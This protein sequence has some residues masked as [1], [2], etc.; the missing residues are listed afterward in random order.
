MKKITFPKLVFS[1]VLLFIF[2]FGMN[3]QTYCTPGNYNTGYSANHY[4]KNVTF[5][6][7]NNNSTATKLTSPYNKYSDYSSLSTIVS[8]NS[9]YPIS[10]TV[11]RDNSVWVRV[12]IDYNKNGIFTD[13]GESVIAMNTTNLPT[14]F[15]F[16]NSFI[17]PSTASFGYLRMRVITHYNSITD[18]CNMN[19]QSAEIEDY[20]LIIQ[21]TA[22]LAGNDNFAVLKNS[23]SGIA[24]QI[25]VSNNDLIGTANPAAGDHYSA[26]ST[27]LNGGAISEITD[28]VFQY[29]PAP[30]FIGADSF[31]YTFC[32]N[33]GSC[34]TAVVSINV[35]LAYCTPTT[36][37][38]GSHFINSVNLIGANATSINN[39]SG[40]NGGYGNFINLPAVELQKGLSYTL[41][42]K[43][44]PA[45]TSTTHRSGWAGYV[46]FNQNGIFEQ[47]SEVVYMTNGTG[48]EESTWPYLARTINI[49]A[50]ASLGRTVMRIGTRRYWASTDPCGN[51]SQPEE[52]EDYVVNV[53]GVNSPDIT[54][55]GNS[56]F[57]TNNSTSPNTSNNTS[58]GFYDV[59]LGN[60]TK[61]FTIRNDGSQPLNLSPISFFSSNAAFTLT[62]PLVT[63]VASNTF[64]T[65]TVSFDPSIVG[66]VEATI[67]IPSND[68]NKNPF[69]F[70][71]SGEGRKTFPDTDG[72]GIT[73]NLDLDD[74][75]DGLPDGYENATC[76]A[77]SRSTTA[78][79]TFL[80]EDFG[81]GTTRVPINGNVPGATTTYCYEDGTGSLCSNS[82]NVDDGDYTIYYT[83]TDKNSSTTGN[84]AIDVSSWADAF[85]YNGTDHTP[86]DTNGRMA[87]FNAAAE[88]GIFYST[89]V[90][91]ITPNV[92]IRF[93][94]YAINLDRTDAPCVNGTGLEQN[95]TTPCSGQ[96]RLRPR[97]QINIYDPNGTLVTSVTSADIQPTTNGN[98]AGDWIEVSAS[99]TST[100]SQFTV[101]LR[102]AQPG[103]LGNDLAIDDIYVKQ[104]LCDL[105]GDGVA[106]IYDL[107]NDDD[108]I[109]NVIEL[110]FPDLDK[111][112]M[113][114]G[115]GW[116]DGNNNGIHDT[117][118]AYGLNPI[119]PD[120]DGDGTPDYIDLDS[121][122][123]S[124]F[125]N[126][127]YDGKGDI[128]VDGNGTGDAKDIKSKLPNTDTD[129]DGI[130]HA[131]DTK[132]TDVDDR[133]FG[134]A[135]YA[136]P[137]DSD[138]DGIPDYRDVFHNVT[139][140]FDIATTIYASYDTNN[141]GR[142]DGT[143]DADKDGVLDI[144]D[145]DDIKNGSPRLL[146]N[147]YTLFFDGRNDY[148]EDS[149]DFVLGRTTASIMAWIKLENATGNEIVVG[150]DK[151]YL[152][153]VNSK[154]A[155]TINNAASFT[156]PSINNTIPLG[157]WCH[158][159][160]TYDGGLSS[161]KLKVYV[162]GELLSGTNVGSGINTSSNKL[163]RIGSAPFISNSNYFKGQIEEV[164]IFGT[165]LT[166]D[167]LQKMVYQ[168]LKTSDFKRGAVV[169]LD[170]PSLSASALLR[171]YQMDIFNND[172]TDNVVTPII[173]LGSGAKLYNIKNIYFQTAPLPY[174][175]KQ[176][177]TWLLANTW[178]FGTVWDINDAT[179]VKP[180]SIVNIKNNVTTVNDHQNA[181]LLVDA[182][183]KLT[184]NSDRELKNNWYLL[185]NG[186]IDLQGESQLIQTA[187]S[188]LDVA[189]SGV[190]ERDQKGTSNS[191][192]YNYFSSPVGP[193]NITSNNNDYTI[194]SVLKDGTDPNNPQP[195]NFQSQ[196][197]AADAAVTNPITISS[198]WMYKYINNNGQYANW[199][200]I[201]SS[202]SLKVGESY[203]MKGSNG[204]GISQNY[205]YVGKP[206]NGTI[207][208]TATANNI[209]LVGNPYAS[210]LNA[211]QFI[212][213]NANL[214][215][216]LYFWEHFGNNTHV[217][218]QYQGGYGT[219]NLSGG[220]AAVSLL[221]NGGTATKIPKQ[222]IP[223]AQGFFVQAKASGGSFAFN[224]SQRNY[225]TET[226][227]NSVFTKSAFNNQ[228]V[229]PNNQV[230]NDNRPKIR[231]NYTSPVG[232][233]RGLLV[234]EDPIAT[235]GYEGKY[236][237]AILDLQNEDA[238]WQIEDQ[239]C[240]IQGIPTMNNAV[241]LPLFVKTSLEGVGTFE[242]T[243][244]EN[245]PQEKEIFL[246]DN[247]FN[248]YHNLRTSN[249]L[250]T[251]YAGE[252]SSRF[253]L[254]F[255]DQVLSNSAFDT[256]KLSVIF[257]N[258]GKKVVIFNPNNQNI[259]SL[260]LYNMLGQEV[261]SVAINSS[262][263]KI[264]LPTSQ[265][266]G[267]YIV[268]LKSEDQSIS[269]KIIIQ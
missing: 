86:N 193:V 261:Y 134:M 157:I 235:F 35:N 11:A 133:D 232:V 192:R 44:N 90:S 254:V 137:L 27:T 23:T 123:D 221:G 168:E 237:G 206:N 19:G 188:I 241:T 52:F 148:V 222:Y 12:Y 34:T 55:L 142:I 259:D 228:A 209:Y 124:I 182:T 60:T 257:Q 207:T 127:E 139:G 247:L 125:D 59:D 80:D 178:K 8:R 69:R 240:V 233:V 187:A 4:I 143:G 202:G 10:I 163:F 106:D 179:K 219:Y 191:F 176:D 30:S 129:G 67:T 198:Y 213:D 110:N 262:Q 66:T 39:T 211:N 205:V 243:D 15:V 116:I 37:S 135:G 212:N 83:V 183:K 149:G 113:V 73:D 204:A 256:N 46:D 225:V 227:G 50:S 184:I 245:I 180:W 154:L 138:G 169:P 14:D 189:S 132:D 161:D 2:S 197:W 13:A 53:I 49:P 175:T 88:P 71:V 173:D 92:P 32:N 196:Y 165:A 223:V 25:N 107:D 159:A 63:S 79:V 153:I 61:T 119:L 43:G 103:G 269:K 140:F 246:K 77:I 248:I 170:I 236:D 250:T 112:G 96:P 177:G 70:K 47:P 64:T 215:G 26:P 74:D 268:I 118:E 17:I 194:A 6:S 84:Y 195:I 260:V 85:W 199:S 78:E 220:V 109:L 21:P 158:I 253:E 160:A 22:P 229:P 265:V 266:T 115:T 97:V 214:T 263:S 31:T 111:N 7:I 87:I 146:N 155:V 54:V 28:G 264:E 166:S 102:N 68:T 5:G 218:A 99:F 234:T 167:Q 9:T 45:L 20:S 100:F 89:V 57:I 174:E 128:D 224:N 3:S 156:S 114:S 91:G 136:N 94:F 62:Q 126:V 38:S 76:L 145:T 217:T 130:L 82:A 81:S 185:L 108:G 164:R 181:G 190:I 251:I 252:E 172:I 40:N 216:T 98:L 258:Q 144:F 42:V 24:N 147:K 120:T 171:Y 1:F 29:I 239:K 58:F 131:I 226:S 33:S 65:F 267:T 48:G 244:L 201:G 141:D 230:F 56:N 93:G 152:S 150:Q 101:E 105:D 95:G 16:N 72:D 238:T 242:I 41:D 255:Q 151:F 200:F 18:P 75:N 186:K 117:Y 210:A 121:D 104:T 122:N 36:T 51:A 203:T 249:Y 231:L 162:N 208:L